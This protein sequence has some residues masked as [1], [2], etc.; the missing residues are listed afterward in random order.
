MLR[1]I[2]RIRSQILGLV[3]GNLL[4]E[5]SMDTRSVVTVVNDRNQWRRLVRMSSLAA[6]WR[7]KKKTQSEIRD[8]PDNRQPDIRYRLCG[9]W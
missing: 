7:E 8:V 6:S 9:I 1:Y 2:E 4:H 5:L 3:N